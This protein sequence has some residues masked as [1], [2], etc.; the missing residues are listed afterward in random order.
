MET[1]LIQ[2]TNSKAYK[3]LEDLED[4]HLIKLLKTRDHSKQKLSEKYLGKLSPN[5]ADEMQIHVKKSR[6][7]WENRDI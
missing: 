3:L 1:V 5:V 2:V 6:E 4:L 7:E